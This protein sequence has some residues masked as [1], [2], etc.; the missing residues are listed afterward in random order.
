[1]TEITQ[2]NNGSS[3]DMQKLFSTMVPEIGQLPQTFII[4]QLFLTFSENIFLALSTALFLYLSTPTR[5]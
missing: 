4:V 3:T 2:K 1:M 5:I